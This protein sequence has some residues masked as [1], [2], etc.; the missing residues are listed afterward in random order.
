MIKKR[1]TCMYCEEPMESVTAKKKFCSDKCKVYWHRTKKKLP[2]NKEKIEPVP[3][4]TKSSRSGSK[5]SSMP[6]GL[7][8]IAQMRWIR[9]NS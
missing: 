5:D 1:E 8:R 6:Q 2:G 9:E 4:K 7:G 3:N